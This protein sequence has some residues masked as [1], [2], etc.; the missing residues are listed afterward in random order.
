MGKRSHSIDSQRSHIV[1]LSGKGD[2]SEE[3]L[4]HYK[5]LIDEIVAQGMRPV[6]TLFHWDMPLYLELLYG[7]FGSESIAED[8]ASYAQVMFSALGSHGVDLWL[9]FS[10]P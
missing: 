7:G 3:G 6:V 4:R 1:T 10:D 9:T 2:I 5:D 8:F